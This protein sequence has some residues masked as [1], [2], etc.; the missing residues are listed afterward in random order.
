MFDLGRIIGHMGAFALSITVVLLVMALASLA[1]FFERLW[2]YARSRSASKVFAREA[3]PLLEAND[4]RSLQTKAQAAKN[5]HLARLILG[6]L[7]T[8]E[9]S[10]ARAASSVPP[11]ELTRRELMRHSDALAADVRRGMGVLA[12]VGSVAPFVGLLGTVVGII[13]AFQGIAK[14]GSGGLGAVSAGISEALV[15]TAVGLLVAIP[16]VL[17]Y[18]WLSTRET[19]SCWRLTKRAVSSSTFSKRTENRPMASTEPLDG[20]RRRP[21]SG[22]KAEINVTPL[23]DVVLVLLIIFMVV[24]PTLEAGVAV[25]LPSILNPDS[26]KNDV[27]PTTLTLTADGTLF[28]EKEAVAATEVEARLGRFR[29]EKP[30]ARLVLKADRKLDYGKVRALFKTCQGLGFPGVALQ[31]LDRANQQGGA[32]GV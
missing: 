13:D 5:S 22:V 14:E 12:S 28:L 15:V 21:I 6:G 2:A 8:F 19:R 27:E 3:R 32:H 24:T 25:D 18:N 30:D 17:A 23:V 20:E 1:V 7:K 10:K 9:A 4:T 31:V 16:A 11:A 26:G 29:A